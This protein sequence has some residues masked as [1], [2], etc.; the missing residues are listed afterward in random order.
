MALPLIAPASAKVA[1][2]L[3]GVGGSVLSSL[4]GNSLRRSAEARA[5]A[6]NIKFWNMQN[7]YNHPS[8]QMARLKAAGLN[9]NLVYGG[10][11]SGTS[12]AASPIGTAKAAPQDFQN[13][14]MQ[15]FD[16][17]KSNVQSNNTIAQT[18]L[19]ELQ[20]ALAVDKLDISGATKQFAKELIE[21]NLQKQLLQNIKI[22][23][24]AYTKNQ[25]IQ[26]AIEQAATKLSSAKATLKGTQLSNEVKA[27]EVNLNK[28][29][30]RSSD[31][32]YLRLIQ[33]ILGVDPKN[34]NANN[35]FGQLK[36]F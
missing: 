34:I 13:P 12:G 28:M 10:S 24:E 27:F 8:Q 6:Q 14:V 1:T 16:A 5:N 36:K 26:I 18:N 31:P 9:P 23:A 20:S 25:T 17:V 2:A 7:Q 11:P 32:F 15:G 19:T 22:Q 33:Q 3:K 35:P 30:I 4:F 29:G 21:A